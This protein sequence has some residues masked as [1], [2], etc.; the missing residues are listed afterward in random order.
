MSYEVFTK[1]GLP[2]GSLT[3]TEKGPRTV[4]TY[5]YDLDPGVSRLVL[6][7][8]RRALSLGI[9]VQHAGGLR[10]SKTMTRLAMGDF[11]LKGEWR[12]MLI[13]AGEEL[14]TLVLAPESGPAAQPDAEPA[15]SPAPPP[16]TAPRGPAPEP[17]TPATPEPETPAAPEPETPEGEET[18]PETVDGWRPENDPARFF[19]DPVL[20][21][22]AG[23]IRG[24]LAK[25]DGEGMLLAFPWAP[26]APFPMIEAFRLGT[27]VKIGEA[28]YIVFRIK[29]GRPV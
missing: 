3:V 2:A 11:S 25:P 26:S 28:E 17:E 16:E 4:F 19:S 10:L 6:V 20:A 22:S 14:S 27:A 5:T 9:P 29:D 23:R 1:D 13:P 18:G 12:A 15:F 24:A 21:A 7:T 8:P